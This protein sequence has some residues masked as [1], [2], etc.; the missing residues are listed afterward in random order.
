MTLSR[1]DV[2]GIGSL[3]MLLK[4]LA[5]TLTSVLVESCL[6]LSIILV[7]ISISLANPASDRLVVISITKWT[8][9]LEIE[10]QKGGPKGTYQ[11][12]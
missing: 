11:C 4:K 7:T 12:K 5:P 6:R 1:L 8:S 2:K 9:I 10:S 3:A